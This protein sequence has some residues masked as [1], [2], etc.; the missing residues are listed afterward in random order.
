MKA[1]PSTP[2]AGY[3]NKSVTEV[4][5]WFRQCSSQLL[6]RREQAD[7]DEALACLFGYH[8]C[9][10][11]IC[12]G[13]KLTQNSRIAHTFTLNPQAA[14]AT[15]D[16]L[17]ADFYRLPLASD[18]V[19]VFLLHHALD[20]SQTPHQLLAEVARATIPRGHIIIVGFNPWSFGG[21]WRVFKRFSSKRALWQQRHLRVGRLYDWFALLN[22]EVLDVKWGHYWPLA[23]GCSHSTLADKFERMMRRVNLPWGDYYIITVRK[24]VIGAIPLRPDWQPA[25]IDQLARSVD[26]SQGATSEQQ[27]ERQYSG[28]P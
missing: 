7:I 14:S 19:D 12:Q 6:L 22:L 5:A 8:L 28:N 9:Q 17:C 11:S 16:D 20:Y 13:I 3:L 23:G 18:S 24:D 25:G 10:I 26:Q 2:T 21:G 15:G 4:T 1:K 27:S